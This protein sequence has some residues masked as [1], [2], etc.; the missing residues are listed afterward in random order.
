MEEI[1]YYYGLYKRNRGDSKEEPKKEE[2]TEPKEEESKAD[3]SP[4]VKIIA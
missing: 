3:A 4:L 2:A 1:G